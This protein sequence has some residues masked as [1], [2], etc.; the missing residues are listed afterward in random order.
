MVL[1]VGS[2]KS[3]WQQGGE[4]GARPL[5]QLLVV[6]L[7]FSL[8]DMSLRSLPPWLHGL[9]LFLA[10]SSVSYKD[11]SLWTQGLL[12]SSRVSVFRDPY[13]HHTHKDSFF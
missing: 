12:T 11:T 8:A 13:L 2:L 7:L 4:V 3:G 1:E 10:V 9:F 5:S 6:A